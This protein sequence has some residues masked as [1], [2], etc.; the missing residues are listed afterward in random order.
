MAGTIAGFLNDVPGLSDHPLGSKI[1]G[2]L[3]GIFFVALSLFW[4]YTVQALVAIALIALFRWL[5][6][7]DHVKQMKTE[8][9]NARSRRTSY[10]SSKVR[11]KKKNSKSRKKAS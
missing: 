8:T 5:V 1:E 2:I 6:V 3:S 9:N 7:T 11:K 10:T 4:D